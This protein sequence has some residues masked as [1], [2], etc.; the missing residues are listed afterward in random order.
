MLEGDWLEVLPEQREAW[1]RNIR[2][3]AQ[4]LQGQVVEAR[5]V[6]LGHTYTL[7]GTVALVA[8]ADDE[9]CRLLLHDCP[10]EVAIV[11]G[12]PGDWTLSA[13]FTPFRGTRDET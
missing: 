9:P 11:E 13:V 6:V 1:P 7:I 5:S 3:C 12:K 4:L 2:V 10:E 8:K